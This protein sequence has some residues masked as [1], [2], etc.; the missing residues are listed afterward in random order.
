VRNMVTFTVACAL[1]RLMITGAGTR[2]RGLMDQALGLIAMGLQ[3]C[4]LQ[5]IAS[6]GSVIRR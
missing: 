2:G 6:A 4:A 5:K 3:V 1:I